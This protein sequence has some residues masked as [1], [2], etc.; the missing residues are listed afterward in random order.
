MDLTI[1]R[2]QYEDFT[3]VPIGSC[4]AVIHSVASYNGSSTLHRLG[5]CGLVDADHR[6]VGEVASLREHKVYVLPVAEIENIL[7]LPDVFI[8]SRGSPPMPRSF[9]NPNKTCSGSP[10]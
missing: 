9:R 4:D 5:A 8:A 6:D 1:Y 10:V 7:L 2:H 3:I